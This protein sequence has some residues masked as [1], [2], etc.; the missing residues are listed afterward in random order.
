M[1]KNECL[2]SAPAPDCH[3]KHKKDI[4]HRIKQPPFVERNKKHKYCC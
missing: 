3:E 2:K 4:N 1:F